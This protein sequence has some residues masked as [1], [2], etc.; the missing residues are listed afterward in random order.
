M[1]KKVELTERSGSFFA[2][3][4]FPNLEFAASDLPFEELVPIWDALREADHA[5]AKLLATE[6]LKSQED[7]KDEKRAAIKVALAAAELK[8]GDLNR[9]KREAGRA[10]DLH[11][12]QYAAH[13][14]LLS[15]LN[16]RQGFA[17]AYLQL[18]NL[19]LPKKTPK[20]DEPLTI[21]EIHTALA[22]WAWQ[23]GEWDDVAKH[24]MRAYPTGLVAMPMEIREEWFR[25]S[26]YRG[27]PE[28]AAAA[29]ALIIEQSPLES[30]DELLQTI[31]Q[32]GW[33]KEA[34]PLYRDAYAK[35]PKSE[36][37]RRRLVAL[38]IREG[39]LDEAR[40]LATRGAI[41]LAA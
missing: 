25:L 13:R 26:L 36:L 16:R 38:C 6:L 4:R 17:A 14:I 1:M 23:L 34:L 41:H 19:S 22:T 39:E 18:L 7:L 32:S 24:L 9:A 27:H 11:P 35:Q 33:T 15:I 31:V 40:A 2:R 20:W 28:D 29:A 12:K 21:C 8:A 30:T 3:Y 37:L 5:T 10:L